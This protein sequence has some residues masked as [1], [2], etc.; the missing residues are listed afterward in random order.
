MLKAGRYEHLELS[1]LLDIL[2]VNYPEAADAIRK[3]HIDRRR[4]KSSFFK[5]RL[6]FDVSPESVGQALEFLEDHMDT[7]SLSMPKISVLWS[8]RI[9]ARWGIHDQ[10][11]EYKGSA[12]MDFLGKGRISY[13]AILS[14]DKEENM[15]LRNVLG[16][17]NMA[18]SWKIIQNFVNVGESWFFVGTYS[19]GKEENE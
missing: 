13:Q 11:D 2:G 10:N 16:S 7:G 1:S 17:D 14:F 4:E 5:K 19:P 9:Q 18:N 15:W 3:E 6:D 8:G 12:H